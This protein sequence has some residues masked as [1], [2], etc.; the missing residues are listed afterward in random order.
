L[1]YWIDDEDSVVLLSPCLSQPVLRT[2]K[3]RRN[4]FKD[5][6]K[7][8]PIVRH[9][10]DPEA[11]E[12]DAAVLHD[13]RILSSNTLALLSNLG[14]IVSTPMTQP[15][16]EWRPQEPPEFEKQVRQPPTVPAAL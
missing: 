13:G 11:P 1:K 12:F 3:P 2:E 10:A 9:S 5:F 16:D 15:W 4:P 7:A 6:S 8:S 14:F